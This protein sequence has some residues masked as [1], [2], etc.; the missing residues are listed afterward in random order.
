MAN[1]KITDFTLRSDFDA[2]CNV[3]VRD[4]TQTWRTTGQQILDFVQANPPAKNQEISSSCGDANT[5]SATYVDV[6]NFSVA[7]TTEGGDVHIT[8]QSDGSGTAGAYI[9]AATASGKWKLL[10]GATLIAEY[11]LSAGAFVPI[12]AL[13]FK[14]VDLAAG[15]YTYK[16][17]QLSAGG[18]GTTF[19]RYGVMVVEEIKTVS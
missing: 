1:K 11:E 7:I 9:Q 14:D 19:T 12:T 10:R 15:T 13:S 5:S 2:T 6:T 8:A 4:G 18:A 17:Q 3:P 16:W